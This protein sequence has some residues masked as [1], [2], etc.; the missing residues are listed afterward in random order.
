MSLTRK[1]AG[2]T[3]MARRATD[4][5]RGGRCL[6][7]RDVS[8]LQP[9]GAFSQLELHGF[10]LIQASVPAL[11][12]SRKMYKNVLAGRALNEPVALGPVE[13]LHCAFFFHNL[14]L[15]H[16]R[17]EITLL[18]GCSARDPEACAK[19]VSTLPGNRVAAQVAAFT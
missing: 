4:L 18:R 2:R 7:A 6:D 14:L 9:L 15:S 5:P 19:D 13:P 11:L 8:G 10:A 3:E 1:T 16:V 17:P 12:N